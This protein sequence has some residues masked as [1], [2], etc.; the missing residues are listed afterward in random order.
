MKILQLVYESQGSPFGFGG[1]GVRAQEIYRRLSLHHE[2]TL[3]Y[4]KY[5]NAQNKKEGNLNHIFLGTESH[6]IV[7]SVIAYTL[8]ASNFIKRQGHEFD[9]IIENFLPCMPFCSPLLTK[10]PVILQVQGI[11]KKH[12]FSKYKFIYAFPM[13][14]TEKFYPKIFNKFMFVSPVTQKQLL[15]EISKNNITVYLIPNGID[16]RFLNAK[17]EEKNYI[18]FFSRID[19]YQKG[20][21]ILLKAFDKIAP[22]YPDLKLVL[23]GYE[24]DKTEKLLKEYAPKYCQRIEYAGFKSGDEKISLLS[25]A[26]I[27]VLP[28]RYESQPISVIEAAACE[29]SV[30]VSNIP[31]LKFVVDNGFGISFQ[32]NS[33]NELEKKIEFMLNNDNIRKQMGLKGRE[34]AKQFTWDKISSEYEKAL[35][36]A[37]SLNK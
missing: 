19:M 22:R 18:L 24:L 27:I 28:S 16:D 2:I 23:A 32:T 5:P 34:F 6:N 35:Y 13:Y 30:I 21:D 26:K 31:E 8:K 10:T 20:I 29:K 15:S 1:A 12:V 37:V 25:G 33:V 14:I 11:M 36:D 17:P 4:M 7:K 9:V 3:L